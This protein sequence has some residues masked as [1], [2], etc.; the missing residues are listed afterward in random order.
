[1]NTKL[2][3]ALMLPL[4]GLTFTWVAF[5]TATYMD[6]GVEYLTP[7]VRWSVYVY[8]AGIVVVSL[9]SSVAF[10]IADVENASGASGVA[11][12]VYRF[13][14]LAVI[15]SMAA[16]A[17][18]AL[19]TFFSSFGNSFSRVGGSPMLET[20]LPIILV[21][22][23]VVYVLLRATVFR[24]SEAAGSPSVSDPRKRALG[25]AWS[26][27]IIGTAL[28][29]IIGLIAYGNNRSIETWTWVVIQSVILVSIVLGTRFAVAARSA[30]T[31]AAKSRVVGAGALNLNFVLSIVFG[32]VVVIMA[33]SY[34]LDAVTKLGSWNYNIAQPVFVYTGVT[35]GWVM[36]SLL[37]S[38]LL[39]A[40][41][42]VGIYLSI[43][44][45][46]RSVD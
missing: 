32:A 5:M 18:F 10:G 3:T 13:T 44:L 21:T 37:P 40:I 41:A 28:A 17:F 4:G 36:E 1:M 6:L 46:N 11:R 39:L 22:L 26:L 25:L 9:A 33:F 38:I 45:R 43:V 8:L 20:Y 16:G 12:S 27:P 19:A 35:F 30:T 2:R 23:V 15:L 31:V 29:L 42:E 14:S 24:K 34:G 7:G